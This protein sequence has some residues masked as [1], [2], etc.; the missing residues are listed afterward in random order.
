MS[1]VKNILLVGVGGQG[2]ILASK[3]LSEGLIS[4]GYDVK[5]SEVHGMAQRGGSV[6]TQVRFG[7]KV[8]SPI[9]GK[10]QSD[11]IV[12][13]EK[14]EA[15]RWLDHLKVGGKVVVNDYE[16]PS[17]PI[18]VGAAK[19]PS[20]VLEILKKKADTTVFKAAEIAKELGNIKTMNVVMV[21]ALAKAMGLNE[22]NWEEVIKNNVKDKFVD[23]N[24]KAFQKG[25]EQL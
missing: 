20:N 22:V 7:K 12:S 8:Y 23:I 16:I 4:A 21:G 19:Y 15:L 9:I 24:L 10:G 13:F 18:L 17:A 3:L 2:I 1:D 5:M 11:I 25:M 6:T 14:M